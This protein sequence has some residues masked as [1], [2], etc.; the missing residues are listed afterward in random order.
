MVPEADSV[1]APA[2]GEFSASGEFS[3][4]GE[5]SAPGGAAET[6]AAS[7]HGA[8][9]TDGTGA[10]GEAP[11]GDGD[12]PVGAGGAPGG[13]GPQRRR[14]RYRWLVGG[15]ALVF[16]VV[17]GLV[18]WVGVR[19]LMARTQLDEARSRIAALQQQALAGHLPSDADLHAQVAAI[20]QRARAARSLT[21]DPVWSAFGRLPW[22][23]CPL[24]SAAG[25]VRA[26]D[27]MAGTGL[28]AVADLGG[29]LNPSRLRQEMT[30]DVA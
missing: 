17:V 1:D 14:L 11:A 27:T 29:T 25:L 5:A 16:A 6:A 19:G 13:G 4:P 12:L 22:A 9:A 26:V 15:G 18:G 10:P 24:R 21:A 7:T 20:G 23:G 28:P 3:A 30:I 8:S 2:A